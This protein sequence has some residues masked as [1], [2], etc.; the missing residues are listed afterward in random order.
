[1]LS[2]SSF[3][4]H[5]Y[6]VLTP[7]FS[8]QP[9]SNAS[10][11]CTNY[12][13]KLGIILIVWQ[14][15]NQVTSFLYKYEGRQHFCFMTHS[16]FDSSLKSSSTQGKSPVHIVYCKILEGKTCGAEFII[17]ISVYRKLKGRLGSV[18]YWWISFHWLTFKLASILCILN[19]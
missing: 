5:Y 9:E 7:N 6:R 15:K 4:Q 11:S 12:C 10:P 18:K 13:S 8:K 19:L 16:L 14:T 1:M 3:H 17:T 2:K